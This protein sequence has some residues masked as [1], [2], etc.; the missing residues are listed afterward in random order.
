MV[1]GAIQVLC[2]LLGFRGGTQEFD[3]SHRPK[4]QVVCLKARYGCAKR[5]SYRIGPAKR[6]G[7]GEFDES[8][9]RSFGV[10]FILKRLH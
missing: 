9:A 6:L 7:S 8:V 1:A 10:D 5:Y 3:S 2:R 4:P